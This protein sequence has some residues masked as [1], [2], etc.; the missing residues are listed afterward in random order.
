VQ[1]VLVCTLL[2]LAPAGPYLEKSMNAMNQIILEGNVVRAPVVKETPHGSH[3]CTMPIAVNRIYKDN[4]GNDVKE[5]GFYDVEAW[6]KLGEH[7]N[8]FGIKGRGVRVV[9]RLKQS[10]WKTA[11]GKNASRVTIVAEHV[12]FKPLF[13]K[14]D[15]EQNE[16]DASDESD[17][18]GTD[19]TADLAEAAAGVAEEQ[20][21]GEA[22][23]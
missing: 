8:E 16:Q 15:E 19:E 6:E 21:A 1:I 7:I 23:F 18:H 4:D 3:V 5:V 20:E 12:E 10:R 2:F 11:E 17:A 14:K 9:G 13:H 22:V